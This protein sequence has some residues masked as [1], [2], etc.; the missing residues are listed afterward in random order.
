VLANRGWSPE[1]PLYPLAQLG[2][3]RALRMERDPA[4]SMVAYRRFL[5]IWR[6]ADPDLPLLRE[7]RAEYRQAM[8]DRR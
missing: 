7:A 2:L 3:A 1:S 4:G 5:D 8:G 6:K